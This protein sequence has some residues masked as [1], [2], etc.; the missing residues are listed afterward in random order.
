MV[1]AALEVANKDVIE[2]ALEMGLMDR[3][4]PVGWR[5]M[6]KIVQLPIT[7]PPPTKRGRDLYVESLVGPSKVVSSE[8]AAPVEPAP[9]KEEEVREF[10]QQMQGSSLAEVEEKS[11]KVVA[12]AS[13]EKKRAAAEAGKRVYAN[14]FSE[15]DPAIAEF[16]QEVAELVDGNPRQIK[17]YVN[18]FRFYSTLRYGLRADGIVAASDFPTDKVLAKF[19]ALNIQ[20][21]HAVDCL[22]VKR[23]LGVKGE[24]ISRLQ[25][26]EEESAR[27]TGE[28]CDEDW[29]KAVDKSGAGSF[30]AARA[31]T[32]EIHDEY[33]GGGEF[34]GAGEGEGREAAGIGAG[35]GV[36]AAGAAGGA[37]CA[38]ASWWSYG[39][40]ADSSLRSE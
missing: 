15:R 32:G 14:T 11:L 16:V 19:V 10:I 13:P 38:W 24:T 27:I 6:E 36:V 33:C 35:P 4:A 18:V 22:R 40:T 28:A 7:I 17:R 29:K 20:W 23:D 37:G 5:F 26:L 8:P 1:A 9:P 3:T 31:L 34:G 12:A 21:P 25:Y 2:K 30:A 39:Q